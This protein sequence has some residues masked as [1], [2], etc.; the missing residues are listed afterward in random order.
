MTITAL[1]LTLGLTV[2]AD[3]PK[4]PIEPVELTGKVEEF[5]FN[6]NWSSYY[7]REDFSFKL[8][9]EKSGK[10]WRVIS[11]EPTPAYDW[12]FGT[13]FTDRKVDWK[14]SPRVRVIGVTGV[15]RLPPT[16]Y[17]FKLDDP[18]LATAFVA[19]V[20]TGKDAWK[21]YYV[22]NWFH[23]WG[24]KA[25]PV[26]HRFYADKKTPYDIYGFINGQ[27][28]PFDRKSKD[29]IAKHPKAKMFHG[30]VHATKDNDFGF[31][32]ELLHLVGP[33]KDGNGVVFFGDASM[34]KLDRK[35]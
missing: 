5:Y 19:F 29:L 28:A 3:P 26:I 15:D 31:E 10:T 7:W 16:F 6:R 11:R 14:A 21:E 35:K 17:D 22:N 8:K 33:D 34:P 23:S 25:N 13:T 30:L 24:D 4:K 12:R 32:I 20:D 27:A 9:D 1:C 2:A 18:L